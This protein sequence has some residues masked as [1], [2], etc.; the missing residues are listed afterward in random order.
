MAQ[1]KSA[2]GAGGFTLIELM[3]VVV[4]MA[5]LVGFALPA[6]RQQLVKTN[7][8]A[9]Q[10]D[11]LG[12]AQALEKEY[13]LNYTYDTP[14]VTAGEVFPDSSPADGGSKKYDLAMD[15]NEPTATSFVILAT[16]AAGST[17]TGDGILRINHLGQ[18]GWDKNNDG[19]FADPGEDTWR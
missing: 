7:R 6:Y 14:A 1:L 9:A 2:R 10:G 16:P 13:A 5:I 19:D 8:A 12:F 11:L 15:P 4:I 17:Q 18:R 3:I